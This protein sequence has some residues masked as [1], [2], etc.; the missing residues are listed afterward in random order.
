MKI[1]IIIPFLA[2]FIWPQFLWALTGR[3]IMEQSDK[4]PTATTAQAEMQMDIHKGKRVDTKEFTIFSKSY[5]NDEDKTLLSFQKPTR[6]QLLTHTHK[7]RED[8]QWL[9]LSSGRVKRIAAGDK[10][11]PFVHSHFYYEDLSGRDIDDF[12]YK[13]IGDEKINN[14]DFYKVESTRKAEKEKVYDKAILYVRK[15]DFFIVRVDLFQKG[16]LHKILENHDIKKIDGILTP[17]RAVMSMTDGTGRTE[18][19]VIKVTYNK[20][21]EDSKFNKEAL[22]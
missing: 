6:I 8:D 11:K 2:L 13:Y 18:L 21:I 3:E 16:Q 19:Q 14:D 4:L 15:S 22:R 20:A 12:D 9:V 1:K 17:F 10:G 7:G 5:D